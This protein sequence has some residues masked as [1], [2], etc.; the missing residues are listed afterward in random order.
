MKIRIP[1][2]GSFYG[3]KPPLSALASLG[4]L[5]SVALLIA[6]CGKESEV[7][8]EPEPAPVIL[9]PAEMQAQYSEA[10][11]LFE[12]KGEKARADVRT[13]MTPLAPLSP[14]LSGHPGAHL[15]SANDLLKT[16]NRLPGNLRKQTMQG[17]KYHLERSIELDPTNEDPYLAL[18]QL[19]TR[20]RKNEEAIALLEGAVDDLPGL[21]VLLAW[22]YQGQENKELAEKFAVQ[23]ADYWKGVAEAEPENAIARLRWARAVMLL[24]KDD[25][26]LA[27]LED[28]RKTGDPL[29]YDQFEFTLRMRQVRAA[30]TAEPPRPE[31]AIDRLEELLARKLKNPQAVFKLSD[32]AVQHPEVR[33]RAQTKLTELSEMEEPAWSV[34]YALA[35]LA[36]EEED[37]ASALPYSEKTYELAPKSPFVII[38]L[39]WSLSKVEPPQFNRALAVIDEIPPGFKSNPIAQRTR[40]RILVRLGQYEEGAEELRKALPSIKPKEQIEAHKLMAEAYATLGKTDLAAEHRRK[41]N[42][43]ATTGTPIE[44]P[45]TSP[46]TRPD[47]V[48]ST[49][50][51]TERKV[52]LPT[53]KVSEPDSVEASKE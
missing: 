10:I 24:Q 41:A 53:K 8:A 18:A 40:G 27:I 9:S 17:A 13:L 16:V 15:W 23:G 12:E 21:A 30:L 3:S 51:T 33:S 46:A 34:F 45:S 35:M 39:A 47:P 20:E 36:M 44:T 11:A 19:L 2:P 6:A 1:F 4:P 32:I 38:N 29:P 25:E 43:E 28:G 48:T 49:L 52:M 31:E 42:P 50:E 22:T 14:E 37:Y 26:V 5:L 7:V